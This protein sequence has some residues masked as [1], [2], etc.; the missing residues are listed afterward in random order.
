MSQ[1]HGIKGGTTDEAFQEQ[2]LLWDRGASVCVDIG[3]LSFMVFYMQRILC[4]TP[5][6]RKTK[7]HNRSPLILRQ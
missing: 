5:K 7:K 1:S 6:E 3:L 2:R 4:K